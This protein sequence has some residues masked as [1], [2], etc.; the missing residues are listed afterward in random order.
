MSSCSVPPF[1]DTRYDRSHTEPGSETSRC[2]TLSC[3][4]NPDLRASPFPVIPDHPPA[5]HPL[6]PPVI[7]H[8]SLTSLTHCYPKQAPLSLALCPATPPKR[9]SV[10]M[11]VTWLRSQSLLGAKCTNG[12]DMVKGSVPPRCKVY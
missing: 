2:C 11:A 1:A 5:E 3:L 6:R 7:P 8:V 10:L 4:T 9:E 12:S